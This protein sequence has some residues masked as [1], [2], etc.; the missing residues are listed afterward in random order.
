MS[1][2]LILHSD[3][4]FCHDLIESNNAIHLYDSES[5]EYFTRVLF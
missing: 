4:D 2:L 1:Y 3:N 5:Y